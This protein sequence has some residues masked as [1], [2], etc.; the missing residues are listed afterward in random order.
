[1]AAF[2]I[3]STA[4]A[5]RAVGF[6]DEHEQAR[7]VIAEAEPGPTDILGVAGVPMDD[8]YFSIRL[9]EQIY[10]FPRNEDAAA[11]LRDAGFRAHQITPYLTGYRID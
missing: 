5:W 10:V 2:I 7:R 3:W 4:Q 6:R 1:M 9:N 11:Q 8:W